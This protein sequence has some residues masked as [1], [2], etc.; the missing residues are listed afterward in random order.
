MWHVSRPTRTPISHWQE[1]RRQSLLQ[2][3]VVSDYGCLNE[4]TAMLL[5][6]SA[7][8]RTQ[9]INHSDWRGFRNDEAWWVPYW[10]WYWRLIQVQQRRLPVRRDSYAIQHIRSLSRKY[11]PQIFKKWGHFLGSEND[12]EKWPHFLIL[13]WNPIGCAKERSKM[14]VKK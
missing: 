11:Q 10:P 4:G 3:D 2:L 5:T 9:L 14:R 8:T 1:H 6:V 7:I 13:Y 12:L